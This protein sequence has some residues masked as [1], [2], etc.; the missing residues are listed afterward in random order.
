MEYYEK[1]VIP[2]IESNYNKFTTVEKSIADFFI[3]NDK[4]QDFSAKSVAEKL[5]ISEASLSRFAKKCGFR[6]YREFIY[7]YEKTFSEKKESMTGNIR[8]VLNAYQELLNRTYSLVDESQIIRISRYISE[9]N[10]VFVCGKG[11]SGLAANETWFRFMRVGVD[12]NAVNDSDIMRMQAVLQDENSLVL[13]FSIS[14][15]KNGVLYFLREAHRRGAKTVLLTANNR[16]NFVDFCDEVVL[17]PSLNHLNHGNSISPQF[18][19]LV[20]M[21]IIYS[22]YAQQDKFKKEIMH[23]NTLR[24]LEDN[25]KASLGVI[26]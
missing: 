21:D 2:I 12:I 15:E 5:F 25:E 18:P 3:H 23:D 1:S 10:R 6:G 26:E 16:E 13:A 20:M 19:L 8:I 14:G 7:Q 17:I 11:S 9:A 4:S 24:A 22:Y